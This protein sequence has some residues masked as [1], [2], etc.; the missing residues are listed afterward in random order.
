MADNND[1]LTHRLL[2]VAA[3]IFAALLGTALVTCAYRSPTERPTSLV[4]R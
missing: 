2:A 4:L 1:V 3:I